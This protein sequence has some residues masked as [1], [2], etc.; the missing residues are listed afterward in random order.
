VKGLRNC[1]P[2]LLHAVSGLGLDGEVLPAHDHGRLLGGLGLVQALF[3]DVDV[4]G[5]VL[6]LAAGNGNAHLHVVSLDGLL[7]VVHRLRAGTIAKLAEEILNGTVAIPVI[8]FL[9]GET[10][11]LTTRMTRDR[12]VKK[13]YPS[14]ITWV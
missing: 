14:S 6:L 2:H 4:V 5:L 10:S 12:K 1:Y 13:Q 3:V 7:D 9:G 11:V 8:I